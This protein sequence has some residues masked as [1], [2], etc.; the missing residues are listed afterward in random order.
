MSES[1]E[2]R[3]LTSI[4]R[5]KSGKVDHATALS[6]ANARIMELIE[7]V[8]NLK[9]ERD[10]LQKLSFVD[11][12]TELHNGRYF[13][14]RL[15]SEL[16]RTNRFHRPMSLLLLDIDQLHLVN[17][18][19]GYRSGHYLLKSVATL[20]NRKLRGMDVITRMT[21]DQFGVI[22][23]ETKSCIALTV[24]ERIRKAIEDEK[25]SV[26]LDSGDICE[27]S[28]K[29][30]IGIATC[31]DHSRTRDGLLMA[32]EIAT[33]A[34][35]HRGGNRCSL[36]TPMQCGGLTVDPTELYELIHDP[37]KSAV[38]TLAGAVD[39]REEGTCGHSH[40]VAR[41]SVATAR[42]LGLSQD[43]LDSM[44]IAGLLHDLGNL[45]IPQ[46]L[47][48]KPGALTVDE[49]DCLQQH[50][51]MGKTILERVPGIESI[52]PAV[53]HHHERWDGNGYPNGLAGEDIPILA[54]ILAVVDSYDAMT[55]DRPYRGAMS[56]QEAVDE[57]CQCAG[58]QFDPNVVEAFLRAMVQDC[59]NKK[60]A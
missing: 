29:V 14:A 18:A 41:Y 51:E 26:I 15:D 56:F 43:E 25:F 36:Y 32:A 8:D 28:A 40:R 16:E 48:S 9:A 55:S 34:G 12:L 53:L 23:P 50:A 38:I 1:C 30:T 4:S 42:Q 19:F 60:A 27:V 10:R 57:L 39:A 58:S 6:K 54:R 47:I 20:L 21:E 22:L 7:E 35:K 59:G 49:R 46:W 13:D 45:G 24:A 31:P 52:L 17:E 33:F 11:T 5:N 2:K 44:R 3:I 37:C